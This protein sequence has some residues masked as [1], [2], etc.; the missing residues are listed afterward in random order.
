M[1]QASTAI[2]LTGAT[3]KLLL[4]TPKDLLIPVLLLSR[5]HWWIGSRPLVKA[6]KR[7]NV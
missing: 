3:G 5:L 6:S 2:F 7:E 4:R 1:P